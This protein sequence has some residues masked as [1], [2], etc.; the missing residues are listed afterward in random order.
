MI[1]GVIAIFII[2]FIFD[3]IA[4]L[5]PDYETGMVHWLIPTTVISI[6]YC[7]FKLMLDLIVDGHA[8]L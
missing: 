1:R 3:L 4:K 6:F 2:M 8:I 7:L 5:D